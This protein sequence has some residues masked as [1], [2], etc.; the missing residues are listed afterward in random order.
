MLLGRGLLKTKLQTLSNQALVVG[1]TGNLG[2]GKTT[3]IQS[4]ARGLGIKKRLTSPTFLI[5]RSYKIKS[6]PYERLFHVDAYRLRKPG[7]LKFLG[8]DAVK[9]NPKNIVLVEWAEKIRGLLPKK[10]IWINLS[11]GRKP[12]ERF[13]NIKIDR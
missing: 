10:S 9:N 1:F 2:A 4:L 7:E 13:L 8:F 3:F 5:M 6:G 11:H 12:N